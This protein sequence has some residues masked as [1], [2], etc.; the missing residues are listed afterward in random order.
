MCRNVLPCRG[1]WS[2]P[3]CFLAINKSDVRSHPLEGKPWTAV[4]ERCQRTRNKRLAP[5]PAL[6]QSLTEP[7]GV[8]QVLSSCLMDESTCPN[9]YCPP[10]PPAVRLA[11]RAA[12]W[13]GK[14]V[15][16]LIWWGSGGPGRNL[17]SSSYI[18]LRPCLRTR[19]GNVVD[20]H[21]ME[22]KICPC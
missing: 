11:E 16:R 22:L 13:W 6:L 5:V 15:A 18:H 19:V 4:W 14:L 8:R 7:S 20:R 21:G 9:F 1:V 10:T 2:T 12:I 3:L 17:D